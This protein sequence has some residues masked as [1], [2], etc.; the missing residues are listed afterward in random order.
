MPSHPHSYSPAAA[1]KLRRALLALAA[2][3]TATV[4]ARAQKVGPNDSDIPLGGVFIDDSIETQTPPPPL[5]PLAPKDGYSI[6]VVTVE[7]SCLLSI[8]KRHGMTLA[9]LLAANPQIQDPDYVRCGQQ[10]YVPE[11]AVRMAGLRP[12]QTPAP[13]PRVA[14]APL[15]PPPTYCLAVDGSPAD[16]INIRPGDTLSGIAKSIGVPVSRLVEMNGI[17]A[18]SRIRAGDSLFVPFNSRIPPERRDPADPPAN[19]DASAFLFAESVG[20]DALHYYEGGPPWERVED[21]TLVF[22]ERRVRIDCYRNGADYRA[23]TNATLR[24]DH[25]CTDEEWRDVLLRLNTAHFEQW[26]PVYPSPTRDG[27]S[28]MVDFLAGTNVIRAFCG[29]NNWPFHFEQFFEVKKFAMRLPPES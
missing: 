28:W 25:V 16:I 12:A 6:H 9:A 20:A 24:R 5:V 8:A 10:L 17:A 23:N 2:A 15:P 1:E 26:E 4:A 29:A 14:G 7:D 3:A 11:T 18:P 13:E 27:T 22:A 19:T 21:M